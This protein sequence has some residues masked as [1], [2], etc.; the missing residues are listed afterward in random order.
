MYENPPERVRGNQMEIK[1]PPKD[2]QEVVVT[3]HTC[4]FHKKHPGKTYAGCTCSGS[5]SLRNK[6]SAREGINEDVK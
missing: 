1:L 2:S 4:D 3:H 6:E 5:Y